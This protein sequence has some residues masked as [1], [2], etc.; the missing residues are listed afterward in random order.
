MPMRH[1]RHATLERE[2]LGQQ[3][4]TETPGGGARAPGVA[5]SLDTRTGQVRL[6]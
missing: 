4:D 5:L 2:E 6:A 1:Q 3:L